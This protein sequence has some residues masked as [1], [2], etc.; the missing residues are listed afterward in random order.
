MKSLILFA[1]ILVIAV[2]KSTKITT[3]SECLSCINNNK[4]M[5]CGLPNPNYMNVFSTECCDRSD[6]SGCQN[7][8]Y[9]GVICTNASQDDVIPRNSKY[10]ICPM[11]IPKCGMYQ[12][13]VAGENVVNLNTDYILPGEFCMFKV[14]NHAPEKGQYLNFTISTDSGLNAEYYNDHPNGGFYLVTE[15]RRGQNFISGTSFEEHIWV[16][17]NNFNS[18]SSLEF[19][20]TVSATKPDHESSWK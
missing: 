20:G 15:L 12:Y 13:S 17:V 11:E 2:C 8:H 3:I 4:T 14:Y 6:P 5:A 9:D 19:R 16:L 1:V 10:L 18:D 7:L